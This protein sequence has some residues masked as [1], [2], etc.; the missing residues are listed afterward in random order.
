MKLM[1]KTMP[2][3]VSEVGEY[4]G[5]QENTVQVPRAWLRRLLPSPGYEALIRYGAGNE[6]ELVLTL[7]RPLRPEILSRLRS[8]EDRAGLIE[9]ALAVE[10]L[11]AVP[12]KSSE[13]G[14]RT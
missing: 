7:S 14:E 12:S 13:E 8:H 4:S 6:I 5:V 9:R 3:P 1:M 10:A 2:R 11:L